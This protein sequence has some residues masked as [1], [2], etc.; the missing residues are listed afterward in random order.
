MYAKSVASMALLIDFTVFPANVMV[1]VCSRNAFALTG[2][3]ELYSDY[4]WVM[5]VIKI[6]F[7]W[8]LRRNGLNVR[9]S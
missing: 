1:V 3:V 7:D 5:W 2:V 4:F 6:S 8:R 9:L